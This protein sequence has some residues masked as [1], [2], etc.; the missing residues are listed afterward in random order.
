MTVAGIDLDL[1]GSPVHEPGRACRFTTANAEEVLGGVLTP[2][3]WSVYRANVEAATRRAWHTLG[4][5]ASAEVPAPEDPDQRFYGCMYG[6][7][8]INVDVFGAA[9]D[10]MPGASGAALEQQLFG[11]AWDTPKPDPRARRRYPFVLGLAGAGVVRAIRRMRADPAPL[12]AW[13]QRTVARGDLGDPAVAAAVNVEAGGWYART[14][15]DHIVVT[16]ISQGVFDAVAAL[17]S[18]AGCAGLERDLITSAAGTDE[19]QV[20]HDLWEISRDRLG[21]EAFL[22]RHGY[23]GPRE[24]V[25]DAFMWRERPELVVELAA[26]Y[27]DVGDDQS[28]DVRR[29]ARRVAHERARREL[30]DAIGSSRHARAFNRALDHALNLALNPA[31]DRGLGLAGTFAELR[32]LGRAHVLRVLDVSRALARARGGRLAAG[33]QLADPDDVQMLTVPALLAGDPAAFATLAARRHDQHAEL[34][35]L[36]LP[37]R[38]RGI[39]QVERAAAPGGERDTSAVRGV[40]ASSGTAEGVVSVIADPS[41]EDLP[42]GGILVCR[43]TDPSWVAQFI[44]AGAVVIDVGSSASHGAIVARELGLPAVVGT[45]DGTAR[46][47]TGDRVRVD[48]STGTVTIL[49]CADG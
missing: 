33:G 13:W 43:A 45:G 19:M 10:R 46:L 16:M 49:G 42:P 26:S 11:G 18:K 6:R 41:A 47:R 2:M 27:R 22:G 7:C 28:P 30:L 9:A 29:G 40:A 5:L 44:L 1:R 4:V 8:C 15:H 12:H 3:T 23:H 34:E 39:P 48:G 17:A 32:E 36:A 24:G 14:M 25:L 35:L 20:A 31:L 21:V 38:W 37:T